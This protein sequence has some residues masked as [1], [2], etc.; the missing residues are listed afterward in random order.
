V[1]T[2]IE[3][4]AGGTVGISCGPRQPEPL[5]RLSI[6]SGH[7]TDPTVLL[8]L[9]EVEQLVEELRARFPKERRYDEG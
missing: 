7:P 3:V 1:S 4:T 6:F 2:T 9:A 8:T 5:V